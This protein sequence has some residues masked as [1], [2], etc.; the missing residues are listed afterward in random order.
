MLAAS[1][2][3]CVLCHG[4]HEDP[5]HL[6][7]ECAHPGVAAARAT[8]R[9]SAPTALCAIFNAI[10]AAHVGGP[11]DTVAA[12]LAECAALCLSLDWD[13]LEGRFVLYRLVL[14][15]PF[16][17]SAAAA[18]HAVVRAL[19]ALFDSVVLPPSRLR[20]VATAWLQ[21]ASRWAADLGTARCVAYET[22]GA[23]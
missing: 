14:A 22:R 1:D 20:G 11:P 23:H 8:L 6:V 4:A 13:S 17:A 9:A 18:D 10:A 16:P 12:R 5:W 3:P 19:G 2:L 21:W 15:L 7:C